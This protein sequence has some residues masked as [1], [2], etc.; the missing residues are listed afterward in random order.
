[1]TVQHY[2]SPNGQILDVF[3]RDWQPFLKRGLTGADFFAFQGLFG[4][5][6]VEIGLWNG[7]FPGAERPDRIVA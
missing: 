5:D 1:M 3:H 6:G 2:D 4:L 7:T